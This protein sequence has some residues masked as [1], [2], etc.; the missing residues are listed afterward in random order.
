MEAELAETLVSDEKLTSPV[1]THNEWDPLEEVVIGTPYHLDYHNDRSFR[2]FFHTNRSTINTD[3]DMRKVRPSN[4][5]K[6]E[7][8]EDIADL[9]KIMDDFR[10]TVRR[11]EVSEQVPVVQSPYWKAPMGHA[12]MSRDIFLVIGNEIIETS[13]MMRARYFEPELYKELFTEY[14]NK[15]AKWTVAPKSRLL[16]HNFDTGF[17]QELGFEEEAPQQPFYEIMFDGAQVM[18]LGRDLVF[19]ASS[20][21]HR[22]GARW[23]KQHLGDE[24]RVHLTN[25]TDT[26][27]DGEVLPLRPGVLLARDTVDI[28]LL[29]APMRNWDVIRYSW[30]DR[31]LEI[32][33]DGVPLLASQTIGMNVLSLD[34]EHVVVQDIQ[35]PLMRDLEKHGFTP[36]PCRWRHGRSLGGGFHC[37]TLDIRRSG[38]LEDYFSD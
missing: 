11:P 36:V 5:M 32:A 12:L 16:D 1:S 2:I 7:C 10:V 21:N 31:P 14:F 29:P 27:I 9:I 34:Q 20:E 15:G 22:M 35:E 28:D 24:Y 25:I 37:V 6:E 33:Q 23:L 8:L 4:Q 19:N 26:H 38:G 13:P 18:R 30:L 17:L 3:G